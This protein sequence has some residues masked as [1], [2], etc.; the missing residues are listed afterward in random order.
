MAYA[1]SIRT[2]N[3]T[4]EELADLLDDLSEGRI[5]DAQI[6]STAGS[7]LSTTATSSTATGQSVTVTGVESGDSVLL[8]SSFSVSHGTTGG[9]IIPQIYRSTTAIGVEA[10][11]RDHAVNTNGAQ[12]VGSL[13]HIDTTPGTGS[14]TYNLY[15]RTAAGTAYMRDRTLI[16]FVLRG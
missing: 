14:V 11:T 7:V 15:W 13:M 6:S 16:A 2:T 4:R 12:K 1:D 3:Y 8:F 9:Y 10:W 5:V